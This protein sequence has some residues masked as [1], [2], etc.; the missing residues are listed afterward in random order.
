MNTHTP[1]STSAETTY[2]MSVSQFKTSSVLFISNFVSNM[3]LFGKSN[4][5]VV[6]IWFKY[7]S[8]HRLVHIWRQHFATWK[9]STDVSYT[10]SYFMETC[11]FVF[12]LI[13]K[14]YI[15]FIHL[16]MSSFLTNLFGI[17]CSYSESGFN[18]LFSVLEHYTP[19]FGS[20]GYGCFLLNVPIKT[21]NHKKKLYLKPMYA[22][23]GVSKWCYLKFEFKLT[24]HH[25]R[26][27]LKNYRVRTGGTCEN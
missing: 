3:C 14:F 17:R 21:K 26:K 16:K 13:F 6:H 9:Y 7:R 19:G 18:A 22:E 2:L 8:R 1:L 4:I 24:P 25:S 5:E 10:A 20:M 12:V 15:D 23:P 27:G 11:D